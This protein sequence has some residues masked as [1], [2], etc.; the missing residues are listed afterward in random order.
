M[1]INALIRFEYQLYIK[2]NA[3]YHGQKAKVA[4]NSP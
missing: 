2:E 1:I 3:S 4:E